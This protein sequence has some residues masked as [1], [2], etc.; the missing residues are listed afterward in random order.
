M[1]ANEV[2]AIIIPRPAIELGGLSSSVIIFFAVAC[3]ATVANIF[4]AQSLV[5]P[6]SRALNLPPSLAGLIVAFTQLGYGAGLF[7][8]VC[9]GDLVENRRL[10]LITT[11][12]TIFGLVGVIY[13]RSA[14]MFLIASFVL[15]VS[16]VG[17]QVLIPLAVHLS[18][19]RLRGRV[20][21]RIMVG[22]IGGIMLSRPLASFLAASF[23][24]KA[25]FWLSMAIMLA[26]LLLL[27][28]VLP[29]RYPTSQL[30]YG[31]LLASIL[32]LLATSRVLQRRCVYQGLL[33]CM[34][35]LFWTSAPLM[36]HD[37]FNLSQQGIAL[38]ALAGAGG[39]FSAPTAGDLVDRGYARIA[40]G[41]A[42]VIA[43]I[44]MLAAG[45]ASA[46]HWMPLLV[47][48]AIS[49][50]AATQANQVISQRVIYGLS[51]EARGRLNAGYMT[52]V[53]LCG[54][55][56][57]AVGSISYAYGGWWLTTLLGSGLG[58]CILVVFAAER[59]EATF[60]QI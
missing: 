34:F 29:R 25:V 26:T 23:G 1:A 30:G 40:V 15:G 39:A 7:F 4:Y 45:W 16:S 36:L 33:Y 24:W 41:A 27:S 42:M 37:K 38:F 9:L 55:A 50:D 20:I 6:I 3:G 56:G 54:A 46:V 5:G 59:D 57:S 43:T 8:L 44:S 17:T 21:G 31:A 13:S 53:F 28:R 49:L 51:V 60:A 10:I 11:A 47:V 22:L 12:G 32:K 48:A 35:N 19:E 2:D 18:P 58:L 14:L 52:V